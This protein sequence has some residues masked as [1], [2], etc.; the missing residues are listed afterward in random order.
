MPA[1]AGTVCSDATLSCWYGDGTRCICSDCQGGTQY[2]VCRTIQ[3]PQWFLGEPGPGCP[4]NL[5]QAGAPCDAPGL[6]CGRDC[7]LDVRCE[8]GVWQW[9]RSTCPICASPDTPIATPEGDRPIADLRVGDLVYSVDHDAVVAVSLVS[10]GRTPVAAHRVVRVVLATGAVLKMSAG[11]RTADGRTFGELTPGTAFDENNTIVS[12]DVV[13][14]THDA[15]YDVLPA[16]S[17]RT[18][19]AAGALVAS[20]LGDSFGVVPSRASFRSSGY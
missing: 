11:H 8:D 3:P 2:P 6:R 12:V 5:P 20:T 1:A 7:N 19:F 10:V 17:T 13:P 16:S 14:Y 18:Y 9:I 15:T 4:A